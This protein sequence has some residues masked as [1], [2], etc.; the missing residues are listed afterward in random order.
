MDHKKWAKTLALLN[1]FPVGIAILALLALPMKLLFL[2]NPN[3]APP[4]KEITLYA[5]G[6]MGVYAFG[7]AQ[8]FDKKYVLAFWAQA[9]VLIVF[10]LLNIFTQTRG[11]NMYDHIR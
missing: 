11:F 4:L 1:L 2:D 9:A 10:L 6:I 7:V 8:L 5:L 3:S